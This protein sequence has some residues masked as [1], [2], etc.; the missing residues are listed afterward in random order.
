M[1]RKRN[2]WGNPD[3]FRFL[4]LGYPNK[5]PKSRLS[6]QYSPDNR[7]GSTVTRTVTEH[8]NLNADWKAWRRGYEIYSHGKFTQSDYSLQFK[9]YEGTV[10][11]TTVYLRFYEYP[12]QNSDSGNRVVT[13]RYTD[14]ANASA[15]G[16]DGIPFDYR[17]G[18]TNVFD[19]KNSESDYSSKEEYLKQKESGEI[20]I[21]L[22]RYLNSLLTPVRRAQPGSRLTDG[23]YSGN[24]IELEDKNGLPVRLY[25]RTYKNIRLV[26]NDLETKELQKELNTS[27][28]KYK[29]KGSDFRRLSG[30]ETLLAAKNWEDSEGV[31]DN[32]IG[33]LAVPISFWND[34]QI[35]VD[36]NATGRR[37]TE[38]RFGEIYN[39]NIDLTL[40]RF[41]KIFD[42]ERFPTTIYKASD[43]KVLFESL[44][45]VDPNDE[46]SQAAKETIPIANDSDPED[47]SNQVDIESNY[48]FIN[49]EYYRFYDKVPT[50]DQLDEIYRQVTTA[51]L[52]IEA[53]NIVEI[54]DHRQDTGFDYTSDSQVWLTIVCAP[55]KQE[56]QLFRP[57]DPTDNTVVGI[58]DANSFSYKAWANGDSF[59]NTYTSNQFK[60]SINPK[61]Q[62][63]SGYIEL[64]IDPW[65]YK[66][67]DMWTRETGYQ[68]L[69][70]DLLFSCSCPA[71][72]HSLTKSPES[73]E[74]DRSKM[75]NRQAKYP[76]PGALSRVLT[77]DGDEDSV[78]GN[79]ITWSDPRYTTSYKNCKHTIACMYEFGLDVREPNDIP[80]EKSRDYFLQK[81]YEERNQLDYLEIEPSAI[82]RAEISNFD[83]GLSM[84]E[85]VKIPTTTPSA[86]LETPA[87]V[88]EAV[89]IPVTAEEIEE[90]QA[91]AI[92]E[93]SVGIVN[94]ETGEVIPSTHQNWIAQ[95]N[96]KRFIDIDPP[97]PAAAPFFSAREWDFENSGTLQ[98]T[99][100]N[101]ATSFSYIYK[102]Y[103]F[104]VIDEMTIDAEMYGAGGASGSGTLSRYWP[105]GDAV[106]STHTSSNEEAYYITNNTYAEITNQSEQDTNYQ[107]AATP[108]DAN[109]YESYGGIV[110][111]RVTLQPNTTY[112]LVIGTKG[113][114]IAGNPNGGAETM[115]VI[116]GVTDSKLLVAGG[117]GAASRQR[118]GTEG[119]YVYNWKSPGG[120]G[121]F[122]S[123]P[124]GSD[125][126]VGF[127]EGSGH[128]VIPEGKGATQAANGSTA[129]S[130]ETT[131]VISSTFFYVGSNDGFRS[132]GGGLGY[133]Y[134]SAGGANNESVELQ[135]AAGGGG[136]SSYADS[137][138][139]SN[140]SYEGTPLPPNTMGKIV[141]KAVDE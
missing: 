111:G 84:L 29:L 123:S 130:S 90:A 43:F 112:K 50:N 48:I 141:I 24:L 8:Y 108:A 33:K 140:I 25:G 116:D 109:Y 76:L 97:L 79:A 128:T 99:D 26:G 78:A 2:G 115:L 113:N 36:A 117:G 45:I 62:D 66:H 52:T 85:S 132:G 61:Q 136:G 71:Y 126:V 107:S 6:G 83:V 82:Q 46:T 110:K 16:S 27:T 101:N 118:T 15:G 21:V 88:V 103:T 95:E 73:R 139:V 44:K 7:F 17:T 129:S 96:R 12:T 89:E 64:K 53:A 133:K 40:F 98:L 69:V 81:L 13:I 124:N 47:G 56:I 41:F 5:P 31:L 87:V 1:P 59:F 121:G 93:Q 35:S 39:L 42:I 4:P 74:A 86:I 19:V 60:R 80:T 137:Q 105:Y 14:I 65:S 104:K 119:N 75:A 54:I 131:D 102:E 70:Y 37:A 3:S 68:P 28:Y 55:P 120:H 23:Y 72:S 134:G 125:G 10:D 38:E 91:E 18:L 20:P 127:R 100:Y 22:N 57:F 114:R 92:L 34:F 30:Q 135:G 49:K 58:F 67:K 63:E 106:Q 9:Q 11:E 122:G 138:Y 77:S 94:E 32:L 51:S